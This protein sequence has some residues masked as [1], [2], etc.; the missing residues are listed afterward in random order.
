MDDIK[1]WL[2]DDASTVTTLEASAS[3]ASESLLE[4][5][6][7][8]NP[9][10]LMPGLTLVGRQTPT[11][12]GPLDLLG[13]DSDG[14]LVVFE[15]KRG[16]LSRDA[17]AQ[18]IDYAS[19]LESK[20]DIALAEHITANSGVG[21]I[22]KI[23]DF[24]SWYSDNRD[25]DSLGALRPLRLFLIGLRADDRTERMV[26]FLAG[27]SGMDISLLAFQG[28]MHEGK[29]LLARQVE[30][31]G[32][33]EPR[34][35]SGRRRLSA[36]E[37]KERLEKRIEECGVT[38]L[39]TAAREIFHEKWHSCK[40]NIGPTAIGFLLSERTESGRRT[41]SYARIDVDQGRI[42]PVFYGRAVNLCPDEFDQAKQAIPFET[43]R[44]PSDTE[45]TY[46]EV[47]FSLD[48]TGWDTHKERLAALMQAVYQAWGQQD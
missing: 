15:L 31:E 3:M 1:V 26:R 2:V 6:L 17:V 32:A 5:V 4:E 42:R 36:A 27:N 24:E 16:I 13:V 48:A 38:E 9:D 25:V 11:E 43:Y 47:K 19:D 33:T 39:L 22:P 18:I 34:G 8:K 28:F 7:V 40:E 44:G 45:G 46:A 35:P 12:G 21:G 10:L 23:D 41:L 30:V 37:K 29:T 20:S 14:R